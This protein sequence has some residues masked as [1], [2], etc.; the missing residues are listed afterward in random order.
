LILQGH[1][2][3]NH[4]KLVAI[5]AYYPTVIPSVHTKY[6]PSI[7][8][9]VHLAGNEIGVQH[10]PEV[11]GIQGKA[12][13]TKK[14]IDP[15][16][17][18]G[19]CLNISFQAYTY[20]GVQSGFAERDLE[21]FDPVAEGVA[22]TRSLATVR[23]GF[24]V[25]PTFEHTRDEMVDFEAAGQVDKA[26][27]K[28]RPYA[29]LINGPTL[30][31]GIGTKDLNQ[32]YTSFFQPLPPTFRARL[33]SRT[34]GTDRIADEIFIS[35][36]HSQEIPWILPT[37]PATNKKVEVVIVSI[38][39]MMG[40][41]LESEHVYWDQACVLVQ[42]GLL[43]PKMV[44]EKFKKQG[45]EELPIVGAEAARAMKRGSSTH[46]NELIEDWEE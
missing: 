15:G 26:I 28:M 23:K 14:R 43:S 16:A 9:L 7:R 24:R 8:V 41:K 4:P 18:Y 35:F 5:V 37:I 38:V 11:L 27:Q 22:F 45:V 31:G 25:E 34:I 32:F 3:P 29:H 30:T 13:T 10:H 1:T 40:G 46:I 19:E 20:A 39:R 36:T 17:G 6:P 42:V 12:K 44:P 33:L 2:K 21:E